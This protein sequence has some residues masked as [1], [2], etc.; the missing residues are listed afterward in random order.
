ME[1]SKAA[2]SFFSLEAP[3]AILKRPCRGKKQTEESDPVQPTSFSPE[4]EEVRLK[5]WQESADWRVD[6]Q[7]QQ[8]VGGEANQR[9]V[10]FCGV[11][12]MSSPYGVQRYGKFKERNREPAN[13]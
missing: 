12:K 13:G 6:Q 1:Q 11:N 7:H 4:T 5:R 10:S 3:A 9:D 2:F 8:E